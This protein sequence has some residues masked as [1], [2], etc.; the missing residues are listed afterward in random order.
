MTIVVGFIDTPE[1][2]RALDLAIDEARSK[3]ARL[4]VAHSMR[5][6]HRDASEEVLHYQDALDEVDRRLKELGID[7]EIH[8]YVRGQN[9]AQDLLDAASSFE[10][11]LIVIGYRRRTATGKAI[12]GSHAHDVLMGAHCP[13]LAIVA[14]D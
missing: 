5:G 10:A 7:H 12:L 6:G 8:E 4:V 9:P 11:G 14:P 13:V 3:D 1:G 2:H